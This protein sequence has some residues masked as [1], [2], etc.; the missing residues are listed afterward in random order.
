ME[1]PAEGPGVRLVVAA[2]NIHT[3]VGCGSGDRAP[4][5]A[6]TA[7]ADWNFDEFGS[8][9]PVLTDDSG[10]VPQTTAPRSVESPEM[11]SAFPSQ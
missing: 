7:V 6:Q 3:N 1:E 11:G 5:E 4:G 10:T 2:G 9:P 8:L